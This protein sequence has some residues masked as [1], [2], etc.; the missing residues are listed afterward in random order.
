MSDPDR[1]ASAHLNAFGAHSAVP[2]QLAAAAA[3]DGSGVV[4]GGLFE[5]ALARCLVCEVAVDPK[6][7]NYGALTCLSC[8]AFFRRSVQKSAAGNFACKR[9]GERRRE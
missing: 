6:H 3:A 1:I 5:G 7:R 8:R 2:F 9:E 4:G